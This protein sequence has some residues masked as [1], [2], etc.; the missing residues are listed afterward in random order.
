VALNIHPPDYAA[1]RFH[2]ESE[3][4]RQAIAPE[5]SSVGLIVTADKKLAGGVVTVDKDSYPLKGAEPGGPAKAELVLD[6]AGTVFEKVSE[7]LR[8]KVQVTDEH[9][10]SLERP[11][12]GAVQ[13]A[14]DRPP[15]IAAAAVS[16]YVL[17]TASPMVMIKAL[18]D[19]G[20]K[21]IILHQTITKGDDPNQAP[22]HTSATIAKPAGHPTTVP[23]WHQLKFSPLGLNK[24]DRVTI[25]LEA[26]D[27]RGSA[28]GKSGK[29]D[30]IVF[31]VTDRAGL[32]EAMDKLDER[33]IEKLDE[34]IRA[35]L[36]IGD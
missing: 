28:E 29:S 12:S 30:P 34:I 3:A 33:M 6:P 17:P 18:D 25:V 19:Y 23:L 9:G 36:G 27:Y 8:F 7:P 15:R 22:V 26:I 5:G 13:V 10:L 4:G 2:A 20:V 24:G 16:R 21:E 35:Q 14:P 32:L 1:E 31:L 11:I